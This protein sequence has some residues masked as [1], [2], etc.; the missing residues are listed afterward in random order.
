MKKIIALI[1]TLTLCVAAFCSF[2][3]ASAEGT[4]PT[5]T[6]NIYERGSSVTVDVLLPDDV[7]IF[8][9]NSLFT[10]N[11]AKLTL[12][13][14]ESKIGG[15]INKNYTSEKE[16]VEGG[17]FHTFAKSTAYNKGATIFVMTFTL[18]KDATVSADDFNYVRYQLTGEDSI[19]A[20]NKMDGASMDFKTFY[21]VT[22][23][24]DSG[25]KIGEDYIA[26]GTNQATAPEL[27]GY[28]FEGFANM[29]NAVNKSIEVIC[30]YVLY[31][32][33]NRDGS[34]GP[35]DASLILQYDAMLITS[36]ECQK[37]GDV[38]LDGKVASLDASLVLQYDAMLITA[39]PF[40]ANN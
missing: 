1:L 26:A 16:G 33:V 9:G 21:T 27:K 13:N 19:L 17:L 38:N 23:V 24:D 8:A 4:L 14:A 22:F 20:S 12:V 40:I 30:K 39:L 7:D 2:S 32:D 10:Y 29:P 34:V 5:Y 25:T 36:L 11:K 28:L 18:A 31:G 6:V 15:T 35:L 37:A 3:V